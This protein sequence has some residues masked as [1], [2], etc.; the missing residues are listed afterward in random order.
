MEV[1]ER[2]PKIQWQI[3]HTQSGAIQIWCEHNIQDFDPASSMRTFG[4]ETLQGCTKSVFPGC[5][6][7]GSNN[8][9]LLP[10]VGKQNVTYSSTFHT[11]WEEPFS[12]VIPMLFS[13]PPWADADVIHGCPLNVRFVLPTWRQGLC[14]ISTPSF[15][16]PPQ[17]TRGQRRGGLAFLR[18]RR[19]GRG[20]LRRRRLLNRAGCSGC[21]VAWTL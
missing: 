5:V 17:A 10:A 8:C 6:N 14:L 16:L 15:S 9:A 2:Y 3:K 21:V 20:V 7:M 11:T 13:Q 12:P 4:P 18:W 19:R 1:C